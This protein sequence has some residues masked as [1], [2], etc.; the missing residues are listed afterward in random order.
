MELFTT[1]KVSEKCCLGKSNVLLGRQGQPSKLR[2]LPGTL[3][4]GR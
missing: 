1:V 2:A 3:E 4:I